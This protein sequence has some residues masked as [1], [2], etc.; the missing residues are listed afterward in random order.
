MRLALVTSGYL[1]EIGGVAAALHQRLKVLDRMGVTCR[2]WAPDYRGE[3]YH[4]DPACDPPEPFTHVTICRYPSRRN[5]LYSYGYDSVPFYRSSLGRGI[6]A[7]RPDV[8]HVDEP[9][10]IA[11]HMF[12]DGYGGRVGVRYARRRGIPATCMYHTNIF[13]HANLYVRPLVKRLVWPLFRRRLA[14]ILNSYD[15]TFCYTSSSVRQL[16]SIG[17]R[18]A[19]A[20]RVAGVPLGLFGPSL[21]R[22]RSALGLR[23]DRVYLL[24]AG[25]VSIEKDLE[26][27]VEAFARLVPEHPE[28]EL[29]V[30]GDGPTRGRLRART[31]GLP[32]RWVPYCDQSVLAR[33]YA[34]CDVFVTPS[35]TETFGFT[36]LEAAASG[37]PVVAA[38]TGG[39][40]DTVGHQRNGLRFTPGSPSALHEALRRVVRD[41]DL[42]RRL[43]GAGP[44]F[45]ADFDVTR[46]TQ[47]LVGH[48][49]ERVRRGQRHRHRPT[50]V[51]WGA[52]LTAPAAGPTAVPAP[53]AP[54]PPH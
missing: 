42:R 2:V 17:V 29:V 20:D 38:D 32:V 21:R 30:V 4:Y 49:D 26:V 52:D 51:V 8:I 22:H 9:E 44:A 31:A 25:R 40:R 12:V 10:R 3:P 50:T 36:V 5:M 47:R 33:W 11:G 15:C 35:A 7:F 54:P 14:W 53:A 46:C 45:A 1:P 37:V 34:S 19:L 6:P 23:R 43:G 27:L 48:W 24:Y 41:P 28:V 39:Y 16:G 18:N 13:A